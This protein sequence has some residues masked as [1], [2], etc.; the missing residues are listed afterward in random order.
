M[1]TVTV[2]VPVYNA[3][4][5]LEKCVDSILNQTYR[6]LE[7]LLID[8]ES[9]D[10]SGRLCDKFQ[11]ADSRVKVIHK[12]NGGAGS[13]RNAGIDLAKGKYLLFVDSDDYLDEKLIR[14]AV[15]LAE[16]EKADMVLFDYMEVDEEGNCLDIYHV[17]LKMEKS[18][19]LKTNPE[20]L[21]VAPS[22][23]N[24]MCRTKLW[25]EEQIRFQTGCYHEDLGTLTKLYL[26]TEKVCYLKEKPMYFYVQHKNS[27]THTPN[28]E[29]NYQDRIRVLEDVINFYKEHYAYDLYQDELEFLVLNHE[30]FISSKEILAFDCKS[31]YLEKVREYA[32]QKFPDLSHNKY[33]SSFSKKDQILFWLLEHRKYRTMQFLSYV[34]Q[35]LSK[36]RVRRYEHE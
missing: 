6:N 5:H 3:E 4:R 15:Y 35:K 2:V 16:E 8:D 36:M 1:E 27:I 23:V 14:K 10:Q 19:C 26:L 17:D 32:Y 31:P 11:K 9:T 22:S 12:K 13:A 34:K 18:G 28:I 30:Y 7:V 29:K 24:K 25:R 21:H 33:I 20:L